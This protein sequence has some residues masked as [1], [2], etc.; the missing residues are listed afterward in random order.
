MGSISVVLPVLLTTVCVVEL[1]VYLDYNNYF[2]IIICPSQ[3]C[4]L[5]LLGSSDCQKLKGS[6]Y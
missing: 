1:Y 3:V 4:L 5:S 6:E 2:K